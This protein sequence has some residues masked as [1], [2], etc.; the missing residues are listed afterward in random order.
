MNN[1]LLLEIIKMAMKTEKNETITAP[2]SP[3]VIGKSY[4]VRTVTMAIAGK[5]KAV[6]PQEL[7]FENANWVADTGRFNEYL[8]DTKNVKENEPFKNDVIVGRGAIIDC[9]EIN[10]VFVGVK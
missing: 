5:L 3:F 10:E 7:V 9:T 8:K 2:A 1:E 6:Y 4:H